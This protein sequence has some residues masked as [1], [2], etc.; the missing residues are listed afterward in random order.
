[1]LKIATCEI[2]APIVAYLSLVSVAAAKPSAGSIAERVDQTITRELFNDSTQLAPRASDETFLRRVWLDLIGDIPSPED[3]V[4]FVLDSSPDKRQRVVRELLDDP[5]YGQNWARYWRDVVFSRR[6]EERALIAADAMERDLAKQLNDNVPWDKIAAKFITATGDVRDNGSTAIIMAQSGRTEET[7]AEISR[8]FL[9]IR[10]QCAQCHDHPY[11]RWKREQFHE[12]AAF[13]PR[14]GIRPVRGE[15]RRSFQVIASDHVRRRKPKK[16]GLPTAEHRMPDL[17]DPTA[18]GVL[19]QPKFFL[20]RAKLP[21]G[22]SDAERREHL[23]RWLTRNKWFVTALVNRMWSELVGEGFYEPVDNIGP[24]REASSPTAVKLLAEKFRQSGY[25]LKWLMETI[26]QT[27]AY[28]RDSRPRR[29]SE[30]TAFTANVPQRLRGDQLFNAVL[31]VLAINENDAP[32]GRYRAG[33][34]DGPRHRRSTRHRFDEVFGY[35]PSVSRESVAASIPQV[36]ALMNSPQVNRGI[37]ATGDHLL[38]R[39]LREEEN[40]QDVVVKLYLRCFSRGPDADE[41]AAA[42]AYRED[43]G[44]RQAAFEDLLWALLNSAEFHYRR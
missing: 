5:R 34:G 14:I 28:G 3:V 9:G 12:L 41:L 24:D 22:T 13:F 10:I 37:S 27:E 15:A 7:A 16:E 2:V 6:L 31:A 40:D 23:A 19:M 1:M 38:A 18:P 29:G 39:L 30:G 8:I 11:D 21:R 26:C 20:T 25:D 4:A 17:N 36:L 33:E 35:D 32:H 42:L 43:I 44:D